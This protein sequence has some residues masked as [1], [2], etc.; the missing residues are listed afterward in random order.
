MLGRVR[1]ERYLLPH[2]EWLEFYRMSERKYRLITRADFDG[3]VCGGLLIELGLIDDIAF[4]EP[5]DVQHGRVDISSNDI[6]TNL[7]YVEA[8]HLCFDHHLSETTRIPEDKDNHVI[9]P[10]APSAARVV[11]NHYGGERALPQITSALMNAVDKADSAQYSADEIM[12]PEDWTLLNFIMDPRSGM[13]GFSHFA[14]SNEQLM[15]DMMTYCRHHPVE[16]IL[17]IPD[18][19]E[20]V[21]T[22]FE[23]EEKHEMQL[24]RCSKMHGNAV[25]ADLRNEGT[26]YAGNRFLIYA[27]FKDANISIQATHSKDGDK[28]I[29]AVGKSILDRGSKTSV[30]ELMLKYGG[31]GHAAAGTC[32]VDNADADR[33]LEELIAQINADG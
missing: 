4:A 13:S 18:V 28:T 15:K 6:T 33:V 19:E 9:D 5:R 24:E 21:H 12:A 3:V 1:V 30:G 26:L 23:Q 32:Q 20:R 11:Y 14:I 16:E 29:F 22:Y 2:A 7:P 10:H 17:R 8:A 31:G 27:L 25:V